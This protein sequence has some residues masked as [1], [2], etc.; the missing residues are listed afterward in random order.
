[1]IFEIEISDQ[2]VVTIIRVMYGGRDIDTQLKK[3]TKM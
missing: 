1:M 2:A 3:Y